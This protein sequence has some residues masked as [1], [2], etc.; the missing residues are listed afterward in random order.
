MQNFANEHTLPSVA[1][2]ILDEIQHLIQIA[3][4]DG[5]ILDVKVVDGKWVTVREYKA[6]PSDYE[7]RDNL[8]EYLKTQ[9]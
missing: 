1:Q 9:S 5:R 6:L 2:A 3:E 4:K 7:M 8:R